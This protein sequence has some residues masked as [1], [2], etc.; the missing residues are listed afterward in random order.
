MARYRFAVRVAIFAAMLS[1]KFR[2]RSLSIY[3]LSALLNHGTI[4]GVLNC[5]ETGLLW[6]PI[7]HSSAKEWRRIIVR[8]IFNT[9][10]NSRRAMLFAGSVKQ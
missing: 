2:P 6:N 3:Y 8:L 1:N 4:A 9:D 5:R 10:S 7:L